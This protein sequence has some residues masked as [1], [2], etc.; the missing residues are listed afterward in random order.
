MPTPAQT[1]WTPDAGHQPDLDYVAYLMTGDSYYLDQLNAQADYDVLSIWPYLRQQGLGGGVAN[2][3]DQVRTIGWSLR[4]VVEAAYANPD[5]SAEKVYF[6]YIMNNS[7]TFLLREATAANQGQATGW[8]PGNVNGSGEIVPWEQY[9]FATT[10]AL[11]AEQGV[12][13]AKEL[14]LWETNFI[15]GIFLSSAEGLDPHIGLGYKLNTYNPSGGESD[16]YQTWAQIEQATLASGV[17]GDLSASWTTYYAACALAALAGDITVTESPEAMDAYGWIVANAAPAA[18]LAHLPSIPQFDIAPRL[19]DGNYLTSNNIIVSYGTAAAQ[20]Q[21]SN[22][23][24]LI[25]ET[26][27]GNVTIIGGTGINLLFAGSGNDSLVGGPG[28]DYLFGGSGVDTFYAGAGRNYMQ[29]GTGADTFVLAASDTASDVIVGF[30]PG[31]DTL[32]VTDLTGMQVTSAEIAGLIAGATTDASGDAVLHLS[33]S[34]SVTLQGVGVGQLVAGM[35][36]SN[37]INLGSGNATV[38]LGAGGTVN[39]G[40]GNDTITVTATNETVNGGSGNNNIIVTAASIGATINGGS[41]VNTLEISGGGAAVMGSSITGIS[42][43]ELLEPASLTLNSSPHQLVFGAAA[44]VTGSTISRFQAGDTIDITNL[45]TATAVLAGIAV[46]ATATVLSVT[47]GSNAAEVTLNGAFGAGSFHLGSDGN[48]G[49][50]ISYLPSVGYAYTLLAVPVTLTLEAEANTITT[51]AADLVHGD[52]ID[53]GSGGGNTL[54]LSG[55]GTFN[56]ATPTTLQDFSTITVQEGAGT[57]LDLRAGLNAA[58]NVTGSAGITIV[59][60]ANSDVIN[61]GSGNDTV[62]LGAGETSNGRAGNNV[63]TVTAASETVNG[64]SGNNTIIVTAASIGATIRGGSGNNILEISGGGTA[65]MGNSITGITRV[66]LL[67]PTSVTLNSIPNL[68]VFGTAAQITG[69][70]ISNFRAGDTIDITN[71][72]A[73][74]SVLT[75]ICVGTTSTALT[76]TDGSS[77]AN[78]TL[79]GAFDAGSFQLGSDGSGGTDVSFLPSAGN[80]TLS[81]VFRAGSVALGS[82]GSGGTDT[83][84]LPSV[85]Y[86]YTLP[87]VPVLLALGSL[88]GTVTTTAAN[89][90]PGDFIDAGSGGSNILALA[91]GGNFNLA[92]PRGLADFSTITVREGAGTTL[93][94]RPETSA[95]VNVTGSAGITIVGA[96]NADVINLG[97]GNDTVTLGSSSEIVNGGGGNNTINVAA[98][99]LGATINGGT[100][101]NILVV[102]GGGTGVMGNRIQGISKVALA[103]TTTF[104]SNGTANLQIA[105]S[106]AGGDTIT[107]GSASQKVVSGGVNEHVRATAVNAGAQVSGLGVGSELEITTGGSVTL[108]SATGGS[109]GDPL[110]VKLDAATNLTLSPMQFIDAIGSNGNDTITAGAKYQTLTGGAGTDI[111]TGYAGGYDTFQDTAAGLNGDTIRNFLASDQIDITNLIP[112]TAVLTATASGANT[113]LTVV[114]GATRTSFLM[115]GSLTQSS[116]AITADG[117]GGTLITHS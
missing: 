92:S 97:S 117:A 81:G 36:Q 37:V 50:D 51:T 82:D 47:D 22:A 105:G 70:T 27:S 83:S 67:K 104:T 40:S 1:G 71:L 76:I 115:A 80:V 84:F 8:I 75:R 16:A 57:V 106:T 103:T 28:N 116:F 90:L 69:S 3:D 26:G 18:G 19:S 58:V 44:Q 78:V 68:S 5:G 33:A 12:G 54:V 88:S 101:T 34:H 60:A 23:D 110:L 30:K 109:A 48:G 11:A 96:A 9:Y 17:A 89:L 66:E 100:G 31:I 46:G 56:L 98:S 29:A 20:I 113:A 52:S 62:T 99:W 4:E 2:G 42:R 108:N 39:G 65:S 114:S 25:Y 45:A 91:G 41:G 59:G 94:L 79:K 13:A 43:V 6:T 7:F 85:G 87:A 32:S 53:G 102:T 14:L 111:L 93:D 73:A 38:T 63:I 61:L 95:T 64:G 15:A 55:S 10:V 86:A 107:L 112:G 77:T 74:S 24:Q 35:F 72:V 21:G 49:T